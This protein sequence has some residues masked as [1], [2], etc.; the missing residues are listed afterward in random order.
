MK[1]TVTNDIYFTR[2]I[3]GINV[4]IEQHLDNRNRPTLL[5]VH[6]FLSSTFS[7]RRLIP[8][9][10]KQFNILALDLPPFGKTEKSTRFV[11][12]YD[13]MAKVIIDLLHIHEVKNAIGV[14]HSMGGQILLYASRKQ[15][16]LFEKIILLC[17]S[18][19]LKRS[20]PTLIYGSYLPY[21]SFYVRQVLAK[22]GI[23]NSLRNVVYDHSLINQEMLQGYLEP[24]NDGKIFR[25]L[26]KMIRDRE[27]DLSSEELNK[28]ETPCL[29]VWGEEDRVVP[30]EIGKKLSRDLPNSNFISLKKTGHLVP[31]EKPEHVSQHIF[32][33]CLG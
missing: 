3:R 5:L 24:F 14:G 28:I 1:E 7:F 15:P 33:F 17:S 19:Y 27:G 4:H 26:T 10:K 16:D 11:Y 8:I 23:W 13:N 2:N 22:Q 31:E 25:A 21:F 29:L 9:V 20:H 12:S 32:D 30:V 6:G 18:G